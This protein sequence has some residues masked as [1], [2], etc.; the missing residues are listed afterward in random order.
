M[1]PVTIA[2]V[3]AAGAVLMVLASALV[4]ARRRSLARRAELAR[5]LA[6]SQEAVRQ[7]AT[8][9]EELSDDMVTTR[10]D[11]ERA[12]L[13]TSLSE[14]D[15]VLDTAAVRQVPRADRAAT[16]RSAEVTR[17]LEEQLVATLARQRAVSGVRARAVDV[18][19]RTVALGHGVRRALQPEVLDRASAEAHIARRR[20]RRLRKRE[21]RE[22]RRLLRGDAA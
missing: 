21:L 3:C 8:R 19:V 14:H 4:V 16:P 15:A 12:Y 6:A 5:E 22:A 20:S 13:I 10:R 18:A 9:V 17:A 11:A 1:G 7:L 2:V